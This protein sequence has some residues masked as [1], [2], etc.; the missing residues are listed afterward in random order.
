MP[1]MLTIMEVPQK[2]SSVIQGIRPDRRLQS[3][4]RRDMSQPTGRWS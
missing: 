4:V 2:T 1:T 3:E